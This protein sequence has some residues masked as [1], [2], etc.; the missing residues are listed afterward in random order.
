MLET[1]CSMSAKDTAMQHRQSRVLLVI[2]RHWP[3]QMLYASF[4]PLHM[5][6]CHLTCTQ[7][8]TSSQLG[9]PHATKQ[10][11]KEKSK[12]RMM[13]VITPVQ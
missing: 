13:S 1:T 6:T 2:G 8:L 7:K 9:L 12:N 3:I 10:K 11:I 5:V 4:P